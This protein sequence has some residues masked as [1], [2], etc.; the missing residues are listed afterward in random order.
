MKTPRTNKTRAARFLAAL[1]VAGSLLAVTDALADDA[2]VVE[3]IDGSTYRG[4]LVENVVGSHVTLKLATGEIRRIEALD[5]KRQEPE[6]P[7]P[8]APP[9]QVSQGTPGPTPNV[10]LGPAVTAA[11]P[12][13][14]GLLAPPVADYTGADAVR[15]TLDPQ[16][17]GYGLL[18]MGPTLEQRIEGGSGNRWRQV[19][20]SPCN[21]AIDAR[22]EYRVRGGMSSTWDP[23]D[24]MGSAAFHI[25]PSPQEQTLR[26][27][28]KA[29]AWRVLGWIFTP[30]SAAFFIPA[31]MA[32]TNGFGPTSDG[33]RFGFGIP[34]AVG[35]AAFLATGLYGLFCQTTVTDDTGRRLANG[36]PGSTLRAS[37]FAF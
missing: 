17:Y 37:G 25:S 27:D 14:A 10:V 20:N 31:G 8:P 2:Y 1:A 4:Q 15:V 36:G 34:M 18:V 32:L 7:P 35:G 13:L 28:G 22:A 12:G 19:C 6:T 26:V 16:G 23:P 21:A 24:M 9:T 29:S 30:L 11:F 5:V 33:F 3:T